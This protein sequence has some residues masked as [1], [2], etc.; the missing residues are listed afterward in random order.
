MEEIKRIELK[1]VG[2][3]Q[4]NEA[5]TKENAELRATCSEMVLL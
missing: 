3:E 1:M 5:L 4:A 2:L